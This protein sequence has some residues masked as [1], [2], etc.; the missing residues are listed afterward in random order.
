MSTKNRA[1]PMLG[2]VCIVTGANSGIGKATA[3]GLAR[4]GASVV[5]ACRS[6]ERGERARE[7]IQEA[8]ENKD[9]RVMKLDLATQASVRVFAAE[10][11]VAYAQLHVLVNNAGIYTNKRTLTVDGI[12]STF[13][14]NHLSHVL[15][16][17]LL[18]DRLVAGAPSRIVNVASGAHVAGE[19]WFDDLNGERRWGAMHAYAQSKLANVLFTYELARRLKGTGVTVNAVHP[20]AVRSGWGKKDA[21]LMGLGV[22]LAAPFMLSPERGAETVIYLAASPDVEGVTGRYFFK[23]RAI[24]SSPTSYDE[25]VARRLWEVSEALTAEKR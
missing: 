11:H 9:V 10:F 21:G 8:S 3:L 14:V 25:S 24:P 23:K 17:G 16:T 7:E 18:L 4:L 22:R 6:M 2:R 12:E 20:G 1:S 15:L 19:M 13:A 5:L